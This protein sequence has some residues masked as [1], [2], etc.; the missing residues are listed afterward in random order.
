VSLE[1]SHDLSKVRDGRSVT[2][3][4][5]LFELTLQVSDPGLQLGQPVGVRSGNVGK[6]I[7]D[8]GAGS[9]SGHHP[10]VI[11]K[12]SCGLKCRVLAMLRGQLP[13]RREQRAWRSLAGSDLVE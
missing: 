13:P 10:A 8:V 2:L 7:R 5:L 6:R 1:G 9:H 11:P 3:L 12:P 4:L